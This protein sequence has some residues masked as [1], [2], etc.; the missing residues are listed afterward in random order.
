MWNNL[1]NDENCGLFVKLCGMVGGEC[2][3]GRKEKTKGSANTDGS[4]ADAVSVGTRKHS[5]FVCLC[6]CVCVCVGRFCTVI[7]DGPSFCSVASIRT[8]FRGSLFFPIFFK[9]HTHTGTHGE[10]YIGFSNT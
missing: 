7:Y 4:S 2:I 10:S 8:H 6:M 5:M 9:E 1:L 3:F